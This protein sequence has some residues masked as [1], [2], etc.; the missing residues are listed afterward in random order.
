MFGNHNHANRVV[1]P[2][3]TPLISGLMHT[4]SGLGAPGLEVETAVATFAQQIKTYE[5]GKIIDLGPVLGKVFVIGSLLCTIGDMPEGN[6][7]AGPLN[8]IIL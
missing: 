1:Y 5:R 2:L 4:D 3:C 7:V 6:K 8:C